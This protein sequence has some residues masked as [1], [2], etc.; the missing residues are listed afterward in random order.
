[1]SHPLLSAV[2]CASALALSATLAWADGHA[3]SG[4]PVEVIAEFTDIRP[5]NLTVTP[6]GRLIASM[7]PLDNAPIRMVEVTRSGEH[8]PFPTLDWADGPEIGL[9]GFSQNVAV[10]TASDGIWWTLDMG[11]ELQGPQLVAWDTVNNALHKRIPLPNDSYLP[12]SFL[13]DMALDETRNKIYIADMTFTLDP[14]DARPSIVVVDLDTGAARRAMEGDKSFMPELDEIVID[15]QTVAAA[16]GNGNAVPLLLGLNPITIDP[17][18]EWVYYGG[19]NGK[20]VWRIKAADL[21]SDMSD[22]DMSAK[23]EWYGPKSA[24]DGIKV[25]GA[26]NVYIS[27]IENHAIGVTTPGSYEIVAQ[28]DVLLNWIDGL[29]IGPDG[30]V[31]GTQNNLHKNPALN[32]GKDESTRPF[33]IVKIQP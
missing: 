24:S 14:A 30:G 25:D 23:V 6:Q 11:R 3:P 16:D 12:I 2:C 8:I 1:M 7:H 21:A 15:G 19:V 4:L 29:A 31:Y 5:A 9:V 17:E 28:D 27:D 32:A 13:Q 20:N 33:R 22:E 26:G 18:D 10:D